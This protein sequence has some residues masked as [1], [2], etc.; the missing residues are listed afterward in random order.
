[1]V[2]GNEFVEDFAFPR[3][4]LIESG[5]QTL[6]QVF[7]NQRY[8]ADVGD[9]VLRERFANV[10]GPERAEVDD[11]STASERTEKGHQELNCVV[12]GEDA[13]ITNA[14]PEGIE[15]SERDALFQVIFV[16]HHAALGAAA[17]AGGIDNASEVL[18]FAQDE[19]RLSFPVCKFFPTV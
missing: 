3:R 10:L 1:F 11:T 16:R 12:G 19:R 13:E 2:D 18:A 17:G 14:R 8:K 15:R 4:Q 9:F 7:Q 5:L 6:L